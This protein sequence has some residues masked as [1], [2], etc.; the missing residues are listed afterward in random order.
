LFPERLSHDTCQ[1]TRR[2]WR[3]ITWKRIARITCD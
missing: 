3:N 1:A 2:W